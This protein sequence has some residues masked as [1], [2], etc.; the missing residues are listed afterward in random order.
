MDSWLQIFLLRSDFRPYRT[1]L[2][3]AGGLSR[4]ELLVARDAAAAADPHF[5]QRPAF[6]AEF[7]RYGLGTTIR[8][9]LALRAALRV[10]KNFHPLGRN[11]FAT[12]LA[13]DGLLPIADVFRPRQDGGAMWVATVRPDDGQTRVV[14]CIA[15]ESVGVDTQQLAHQLGWRVRRP[16]QQSQSSQTPSNFVLATSCPPAAFPTGEDCREHDGR[17]AALIH[18]CNRTGQVNEV[19]DN[20]DTAGSDVTVV[21]RR[22]K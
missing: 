9:I 1:S 4:A 3:P 17:L 5:E 18:L 21:N 20:I 22:N 19:T 16:P 6:G 12:D 13:E 11:R 2:E 15:R 7:R 14:T 8:E 10:G